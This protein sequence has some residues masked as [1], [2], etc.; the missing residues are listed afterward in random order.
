MNVGEPLSVAVGIN[1]QRAIIL[2]APS[3]I[4]IFD[5]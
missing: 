1:V 4:V 2:N 3:K 5:S